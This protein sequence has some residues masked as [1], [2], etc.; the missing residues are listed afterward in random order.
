M[1]VN[2]WYLIATPDKRKKYKLRM[3]THSIFKYNQVS[4]TI[5]KLKSKL[6]KKK[7][8]VLKRTCTILKEY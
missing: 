2:T 7:I 8:M 4:P 1:K 3:L 6:P 5:N